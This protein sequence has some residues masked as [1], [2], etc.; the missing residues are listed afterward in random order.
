LFPTGSPNA[1]VV[2]EDVSEVLRVRK[3][4]SDAVDGHCAASANHKEEPV[5]TV[6]KIEF[7]PDSFMLEDPLQ[8]VSRKSCV[9]RGRSVWI[10][11]D[12]SFMRS[13][14]FL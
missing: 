12:I 10:F 11:L 3:W 1:G 8:E 4:V 7:D 9:S 13:T 6:A 2:P 14:N 5:A